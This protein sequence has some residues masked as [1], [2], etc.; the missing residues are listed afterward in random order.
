MNDSQEA[1]PP[2]VWGFTWHEDLPEYASGD[3]WVQED[4]EFEVICEVKDKG[5]GRLIA[6]APTMARVLRDTLPRI[7][8]LGPWMGN[9]AQIE[10]VVAYLNGEADTPE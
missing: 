1:W 8:P 9:A 4:G 7:A 2:E 5:H 3:V 6:A 10:R